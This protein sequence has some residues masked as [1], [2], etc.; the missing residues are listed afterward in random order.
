VTDSELTNELSRA[1]STA[2]MHPIG[3]MY[4]TTVE[5]LVAEIRA[6]RTLLAAIADKLL[7]YDIAR[8]SL[9]ALA[10]KVRAILPDVCQLLDGW[11]QT[12]A[13]NEWSEWDESV[14]QRL[15]ALAVVVEPIRG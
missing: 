5:K 8:Q 7:K 3:R 10:E 13:P 4:L 2:A 14:R 6:Q 9:L 1:A 11:K 12:F 15:T